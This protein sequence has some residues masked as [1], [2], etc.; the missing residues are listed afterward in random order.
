[1]LGRVIRIFLSSTFRDFG[2]ERDLLVRKVFPALRA[3]LQSRFVDLIDVDLRWG[4]TEE[5]AER[6]EVLPICLSEIDRARP[7]FIGFLGERYGWIPPLDA[8]PPHVLESQSWLEEHR[9]GK[10]VTELEIL[11]G[12]LN[13]PRME[14]R[15]LFY[16]RS[17]EYSSS[18][19]GDYV[20]SSAD[21]EA[22][23]SALKETIRQSG[24]PLYEDYKS[25]EHLA[26]LLEQNLWEILDREFPASDIPDAF[27]RENLRHEAYAL[28]R[29]RL[30]IGG[31]QY[32]AALDRALSEDKQWILVDGPSGGG[33]SALLAN[34]LKSVNDSEKDIEVHAHY[35]GAT[36]DATDPVLLARRLIESIRRITESLDGLASDPDEL[37][38]SLPTWLA[39]AS[40]WCELQGKKF[41]LVIDALNGLSDRRDLRWFPRMLPKH[42]HLVISTLPGEVNDALQGKADCSRVSVMPLDVKTAE[43]V[44]TSYLSLF[45]KT[46]PE[47]LVA[48]VM[49]HELSVNPLFLLTLAEELRLFGEHEQLSQ[50]LGHYLSS[51]TVDD[52]FER[53]LERIEQDYGAEILREIMTALWA[54]RAGLR[55]EEILGYSGLKPMHLAYIRNALGPTLIDASGRLIFAHDYMRIAVSDRYMA[56]N[57]TLGN[58]GQSEEALNLRRTAHKKLSQ[59]FESH[60]FKEEDSIV[61]NERAAEEIPYQ[62]QKAQEWKKLQSKLTEQDMLVA[63][64]EHRSEQELLSYWL[65]L[66]ASIKADIEIQ[67]EN[68]WAKWELNETDEVTGDIAQKIADFLMYAGRYKDFTEKLLRVLV[69]NRLTTLDEQNIKYVQAREKLAVLLSIIEKFDESIEIYRGVIESS[70]SVF[71]PVSDQV[72]NVKNGLANIDTLGSKERGVLFREALSIRKTIYGEDHLNTA[73]DLLALGG[74]LWNTKKGD[75]IEAEGLLQKAVEIYSSQ[76]GMNSPGNAEAMSLLALFKMDIKEDYVG[77]EPLLVKALTVLS[78]ALGPEHPRSAK[79]LNN[80]GHLYS[81]TEKY[82]KAIEVFRR[83]LMIK[84]NRFGD[85]SISVAQALNSLAFPLIDTGNYVEAEA[86]F[87]RAHKIISEK[88]GAQ[89]SRSISCLHSLG[90]LFSY[91]GD[92]ESAESLFDQVNKLEDD[93]GSSPKAQALSW[94]VY[95]LKKDQAFEDAVYYSLRLIQIE[96]EK[97]GEGHIN[98]FSPFYNLGEIFF[99][100]RRF[101]EACNYFEQ[102]LTIGLNEWGPNHGELA[103]TFLSLGECQYHLSDFKSAEENLKKAHSLQLAEGGKNNYNYKKVLELL[104]DVS[105]ALTKDVQAQSYVTLILVL[106]E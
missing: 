77:A 4:I 90:V 76:L 67:Y 95:K 34:W 73:G 83:D 13:N 17:F 60:A 63:I 78:N 9:G 98:L 15:A 21:D 93:N 81:W 29:Q 14:G 89:A 36:A 103:L 64:L 5:E 35:L 26:K 72:A 40:S 49:A 48:Q 39:N 101:S 92:L 61:S 87:R 105:V 16:F 47:D 38:D 96:S 32:L 70:T 57:N 30:Y 84:E 82:D 20:A 41:L 66:E 99:E 94:Y 11:Y 27:V 102:C 7:Y 58:E 71:G 44:F 19:G 86:L 25:P 80:L 91:K 43:Q 85:N 75:N 10:S 31:D 42:I 100:Q 6:G 52:L 69:A 2:E 33:K 53:V 68:A 74:H 88:L 23:Q 104:R 56:G 97:W 50:R 1:M 22:R 28:P 62:L 37:L 12:V 65:I 55:E 3:K 8:Y 46:L 59:W 45:N 51:M 54:G 18:K 79:V 24:F 106:N